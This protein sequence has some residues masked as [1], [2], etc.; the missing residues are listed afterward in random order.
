MVTEVEAGGGTQLTNWIAGQ[1]VTADSGGVLRE[2][3]AA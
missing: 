3:L 1:S 2:T